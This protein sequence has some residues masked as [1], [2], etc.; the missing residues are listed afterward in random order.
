MVLFSQTRYWA[1]SISAAALGALIACSVY[2]PVQAAESDVASLSNAKLREALSVKIR[3]VQHMAL[4]P[5]LVNAVKLQNAQRISVEEINRRD[6]LWKDSDDNDPYKLTLQTSHA[7]SFL[8]GKVADGAKFN[9][10]FLTDNQ[11]ANVATYPATGDYNQ[12]D[13]EKWSESWN[14]GDGV[15][16]LG[17]PEVDKS[18]GV[19][20]VQI[21]APVRDRGKTIG[22][23]VVGVT[24]TYI[25]GK[26]QN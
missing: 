18:T 3:T 16:F 20:A 1:L 15:I 7:G 23:L 22:V 21:S 12:G 2:S 25:G 13:E 24:F 5:V 10:A 4:N 19:Q 14:S 9:E 11:G 17:E 26:I 6:T 8:K